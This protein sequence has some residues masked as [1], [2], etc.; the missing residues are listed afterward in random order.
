MKN[1]TSSTR[2]RNYLVYADLVNA[3]YFVLC[4]L[5]TERKEQ[6][7]FSRIIIVHFSQANLR[8]KQGHIILQITGSTIHYCYRKWTLAWIFP[9][10]CVWK[11]RMKLRKKANGRAKSTAWTKKPCPDGLTAARPSNPPGGVTPRSSRWISLN[12]YLTTPRTHPLPPG[13]FCK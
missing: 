7:Q 5:I 9:N 2:P 6:S 13:W 12:Y 1:K 8:P 11:Q 10:S 4:W 3:V